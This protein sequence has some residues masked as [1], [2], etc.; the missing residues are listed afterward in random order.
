MIYSVLVIEDDLPSANWVKIYLERAGYK[1]LMAHDGKTGLEMA[2]NANPSLIL[3]DLMLP[4]L[5]G[6]EI[7]RILRNESDVPIIMLTA[8]GAKID[9]INGLDGGADDYIVKPFDPDELIVR[10]KSVLRRYKGH[11]IRNIVCGR[12]CLEEET[13]T[14]I[15]DG[16]SVSLSRAQYALMTVFIGHP[17][18][19]LTRNQLIEQAFDNNFGA[20]DRA[21]DSHIRRLRKLI[22][23]ENYE[24]LKTL[25]GSGY[26]LECPER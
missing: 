13:Q 17:N 5:D 25:Y 16:K 7:C 22:H 14:I 18:I 10:I 26:K 2:R 21:I 23:R 9:R 11:V 3:L 19:I 15:I 20:F 24:P 4:V 8:R 6:N 1:A 12:L